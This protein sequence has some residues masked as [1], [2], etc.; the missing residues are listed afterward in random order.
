MMLITERISDWNFN[1]ID[2]SA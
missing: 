2:A 1:G